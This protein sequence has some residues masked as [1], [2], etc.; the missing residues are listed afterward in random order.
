MNI[1]FVCKHNVFRSRI[2]EDYFLQRT[3][4]H[5]VT[6]AGVFP[7]HGPRSS[8]LVE[9]VKKHGIDLTR[10]QAEPITCDL[11]REQDLV[12]IVADDVPLSLFTNKFYG[13]IGKI[14]FFDIADVRD[15]SNE[16][17]IER[18]IAEVK[19]N[20]DQFVYALSQVS[21]K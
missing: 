12:V 10:K 15:A 1:L 6:S 21:A 19:Q 9:T 8:K 17:E 3:S 11:L 4:E 2:A 13:L 18:V 16:E 20:V 7:Y 5:N 14:G